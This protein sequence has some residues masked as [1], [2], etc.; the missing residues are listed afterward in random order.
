[1]V[2]NDSGFLVCKG[3]LRNPRP[4]KRDLMDMNAEL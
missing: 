1:M 4:G 3:D 2:S